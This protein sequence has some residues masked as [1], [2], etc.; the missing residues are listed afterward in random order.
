MSKDELEGEGNILTLGASE[1]AGHGIIL[2]I[3]RE[4]NNNLPTVNRID[5]YGQQWGSGRLGKVPFWNISYSLCGKI[6]GHHCAALKLLCVSAGC[7]PI[8]YADLSPLSL[9]G[10]WGRHQKIK[11]R[12]S[13]TEEQYRTHFNDIFSHESFIKR[14]RLAICAGHKGVGLDKGIPLME[15]FL[16]KAEIP[17]CH[18]DGLNSTRV[19]VEH[20]LE[21]LGGK[22]DIVQSVFD[23]FFSEYLPNIQDV[24]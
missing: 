15:S 20:R 3:G 9:D 16:D 24:G 1:S 6:T 5:Q 8:A 11:T 18:I 13:V 4:P 22:A 23:E 21:Q 14:V 17:Y 2:I 19:T 10:G 12:Q 7:S